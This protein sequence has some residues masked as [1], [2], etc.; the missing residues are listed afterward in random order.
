VIYATKTE[1]YFERLRRLLLK[2][3]YD[4]S[5]EAIQIMGRLRKTLR[6]AHGLSFTQQG[7]QEA[8][9]D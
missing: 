5:H 7:T 2:A 8:T 3:G 6:Q 9:N 1:K 4:R